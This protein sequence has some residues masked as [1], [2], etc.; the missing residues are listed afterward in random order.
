MSEFPHFPRRLL[1]HLGKCRN[2]LNHW[3][4]RTEEW[5]RSAMDTGW[6]LSHAASP[7]LSHSAGF[8]SVARDARKHAREHVRT[9]WE[10]EQREANVGVQK[11]EWAVR[12]FPPST[13]WPRN[14]TRINRIATF[15]SMHF[16][17]S[18]LYLDST[19][20]V[21]VEFQKTLCRGIQTSG[22]TESGTPP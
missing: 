3:S 14:H 19:E 22:Y 15:S 18:G 16:A 1:N 21:A 5:A 4:L 13:V 6:R 8:D 9:R 10:N 12:T 11:M 7:S 17:S 2:L 20:F